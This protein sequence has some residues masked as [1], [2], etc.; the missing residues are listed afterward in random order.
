MKN[1]CDPATLSKDAETVLNAMLEEFRQMMRLPF[2]EV[3][4]RGAARE[5]MQKGLLKI[6]QT[7]PD[8]FELHLTPEGT[9]LADYIESGGQ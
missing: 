2:G 5:L 9:E 7:G 3:E 1:L 8:R 6:Y 4:F